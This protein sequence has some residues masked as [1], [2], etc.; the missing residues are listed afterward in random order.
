MPRSKPYTLTHGD[1]TSVNIMVKDGNLSGFI[2]FEYSGYYPRWWEYARHAM[3]FSEEDRQWK[4]LLRK[5]MRNHD[6]MN[7]AGSR[8]WR[9][10]NALAKYPDKDTTQER[11]KE[12]FDGEPA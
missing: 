12:L 3:W 9:A 10:C 1:L 2:D 7:E 6:E 11:L 8:W 5:Y 4:D